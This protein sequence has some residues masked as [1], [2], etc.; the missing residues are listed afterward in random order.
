VK[1]LIVAF[2][3]T[4]NCRLILCIL[5]SYLVQYHLGL[6]AQDLFCHFCSWINIE[7]ECLSQVI[8]IYDVAFPVSIQDCTWI[9][10]VSGYGWRG[11]LLGSIGG[12]N[13]ISE[14]GKLVNKGL[15]LNITIT[16]R[17]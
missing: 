15:T 4:M 6:N 12:M 13:I 2:K 9:L 5:T 7:T 16:L 10:F 14:A 1:R 8:Q 11:L 3:A 17:T